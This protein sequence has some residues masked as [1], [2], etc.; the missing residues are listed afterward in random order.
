[1]IAEVARGAGVRRGRPIGGGLASETCA[2]DTTAGDFVVKLF[3]PH[4][5]AEARPEW[6]RLNFAGRV[7]GA[8]VPT[9]IAFDA[10]GRWFGPPA[11][12]MSR[13][14][15]RVDVNPADPDR[16]LRQLAY[17]LAAIH[18]TETAGAAG[19]LLAGPP[20]GHWGIGD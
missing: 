8:P 13:L 11:L 18:Q 15:G 5:F 12:V 3:R 14:P 19:A 17:T 2:V 4:R 6:E 9:P 16:W 20:L 7:I 1:M 10:G